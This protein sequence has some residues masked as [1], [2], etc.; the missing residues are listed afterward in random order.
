MFFLFCCC[1]SDVSIK[2]IFKKAKAHP[3]HLPHWACPLLR[4]PSGGEWPH[5]HLAG[6]L[7]NANDQILFCGCDKCGVKERGLPDWWISVLLGNPQSALQPT[8]SQRLEWVGLFCHTLLFQHGWITIGH[9]CTQLCM[10]HV[11]IRW[12][13]IH[14]AFLDYKCEKQSFNL[15]ADVCGLLTEKSY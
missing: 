2:S 15:C 8:P 5:S 14:T 4:L 10:Y 1:C 9:V 12:E 13:A 11:M 3:N 6:M 7:A